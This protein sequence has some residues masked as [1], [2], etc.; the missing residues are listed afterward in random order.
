MRRL[1]AGAIRH[2]HAF[3]VVGDRKSPESFDL[4]GCKFLTIDDQLDMTFKTAG[5]C[6][7]DHYARKNIG[8]LVAMQNEALVVIDTDDD[9]CPNSEF[10]L[11]R[12]EHVGCMAT[13]GKGWVNIYRHFT[14]TTV[15]PRGLPLDAVHAAP[16]VHEEIS[17]K[18]CPIQQGLADGDPDVDAIFRLILPLPV[19]FDKKAPLALSHEQWCPFNSQNTTWW[20]IVYPLLYLPAYCSFRMTDIWRSFVAQRICWENSWF[21]LFHGPTVTQDRNMH[22]L[23]RDFTDELPGYLNNRAICDGLE[24]LRLRPGRGYIGDN[25][26]CCYEF[27]VK[28]GIVEKQELLLLD[29]WLTDVRELGHLTRT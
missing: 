29:G 2:D 1:A 5:L 20:P 28:K 17:E 19:T 16:A 14:N 8:Y 12:R 6:P 24:S 7:T 18:H 23:M 21:I 4:P 11:P 9:N 27:L 3:I 22:E 13:T 26:L 25:M 10:F 15:W